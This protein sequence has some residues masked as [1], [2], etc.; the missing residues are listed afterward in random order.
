MGAPHR[1]STRPSAIGRP[2]RRLRRWARHSSYGTI[3]AD[4]IGLAIILIVVAAI[5]AKIVG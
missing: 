1:S 4:M 2:Y 3:A 5:L